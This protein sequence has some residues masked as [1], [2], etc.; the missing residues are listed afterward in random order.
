[1]DSEQSSSNLSLII[2]GSRRNSV[3]NGKYLRAQS[4]NKTKTTTLDLKIKDEC[5]GR[6]VQML[7]NQIF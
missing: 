3:N 5:L 4:W 7:M 2:F 6:V 1:M